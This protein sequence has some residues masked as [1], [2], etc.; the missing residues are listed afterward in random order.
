[1]AWDWVDGSWTDLGG[2][3]DSSLESFD[4]SN[5]WAPDDQTTG[6]VGTGDILSFLTDYPEYTS[7]FSS[8]LISGAL[9]G[10]GSAAKSLITN[11]KTGKIDPARIAAIGGGIAGGLGLFDSSQ[12]KTGYQGGIPELTAV[13][14]QVP[15]T[16]DPNRRPGS[17]GQEYMTQTQ[18]VSPSDVAT[19]KASAAEEAKA[20]EQAFKEK[21]LAE[22]YA[23]QEAKLDRQAKE[24]VARYNVY[25]EFCVLPK[26]LT[27]MKQHLDADKN[28]ASNTIKSLM[29]RG[30]L[31]SIVISDTSSR[32]YYSF[33]TI[34]LMS[35]EE[36]LEYVSPRKYKTKASENEA[37]IPGARVINFDDNKLTKLYMNQ[38]A[39]DRANM[40]SPKNYVSGALMSTA[41]W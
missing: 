21:R 17:R 6:S 24:M 29:A 11:P 31:K 3:V 19:A 32:K 5:Y 25:L 9:G 30:Y 41:D 2:G 39:I 7:F 22:S 36:A 37:T 20:A 12:Q 10:L 34:K 16:Y 23:K 8:D 38:R 35:Y 40:K 26:T 27:D 15:G 1:M 4:Y 18:F 33:V 13:R 28:T 14:E